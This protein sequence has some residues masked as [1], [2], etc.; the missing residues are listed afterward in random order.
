LQLIVEFLLMPGERMKR[1]LLFFLQIMTLTVLSAATSEQPILFTGNN[2]GLLGTCACEIPAGGLPRIATLSDSLGK[3]LIRI[4]C[5]N[6]FFS[7]MPKPYEDQILAQDQARLQAEILSEL[8]F[9]VIN[10]GEYDLCYGLRFLQS[11]ERD[12]GLPLISANLRDAEGNSPFPHYRIVSRNGIRIAFTGICTRSDGFNFKVADPLP[13]LTELINLDLHR[14]ADFVVLLAD[15]S[16][17]GLK[18]FLDLHPG[19]DFAVFAKE[20]YAT[21]LSQATESG[22]CAHIGFQGQYAGYLQLFSRD[23]DAFWKDLTAENHRLHFA[24]KLLNTADTERGA[25]LRQYRR[26]RNNAKNV[27]QQESLKAGR[28]YFWNLI[29]MTQEIRERP[30]I[31]ET[32]QNFD[33]REK[34]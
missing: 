17:K 1:P 23:P 4:G 20:A 33:R 29:S 11:L 7:R 18:P 10:I 24:E 16:L 12:F 13:A 32:I 19:I 21:P 14:E 25:L 30:D 5:G 22:S 28:Y 15:A 6:Q 31:L 3:E 9:D 27:L 8:R 2:R 34:K 26:V